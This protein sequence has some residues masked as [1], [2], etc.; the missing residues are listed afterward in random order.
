MYEIRLLPKVTK[1]LDRLSEKNFNQIKEEID[2]LRENPRPFGC[3][4]LTAEEGYRIRAGDYR[5]LYRINDQAKHV[6][7]YRIKHRKD[8]YR[9]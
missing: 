3:L 9:D 4:K 8:A 2:R 6:F 1:E 5:I 7:I